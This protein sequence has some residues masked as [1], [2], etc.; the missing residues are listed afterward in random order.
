MTNPK[1]FPEH[2]DHYRSL[3]DPITG[4]PNNA[5]LHDRLTM[6]LARGSR[7]NHF[8]GLLAVSVTFGSLDSNQATVHALTEIAVR[9]ASLLRPDDTAARVEDACAFIVVCNDITAQDHLDRIANR[10]AVQLGKP[11]AWDVEPIAVQVTVT[12]SLLAGVF[13]DEPAQLLDAAARFAIA[14]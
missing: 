5:L 2:R 14:H 6:A 1:A 10:L 4:L 12:S 13:D 8:V 7:S 11:L 3:F 9:L